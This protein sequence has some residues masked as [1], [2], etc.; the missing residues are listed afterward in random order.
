MPSVRKYHG[1]YLIPNTIE[2]A[3][4]PDNVRYLWIAYSD[5][6]FC[7]GSSFG[8][9]KKA[10]DNLGDWAEGNITLKFVDLY[11]DRVILIPTRL[12]IERLLLVWRNNYFNPDWRLQLNVKASKKKA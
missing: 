5:D 10:L 1:D 11:E 4:R 6:G 12:P 9:L 7:S 2:L 8:G 3:S